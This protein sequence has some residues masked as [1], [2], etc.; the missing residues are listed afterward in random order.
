MAEFTDYDE[1]P[2]IEMNIIQK[3]QADIKRLTNY[4]AALSIK[5]E[6]CS[7]DYTFEEI[8]QIVALGEWAEMAAQEL[9]SL[10]TL[11][12]WR[13]NSKRLCEQIEGSDAIGYEWS[14][15]HKQQD[16]GRAAS[17]RIVMLFD[18]FKKLSVAP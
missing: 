11:V 14:Y 17:E 8:K 9:A 13:S 2:E 10:T 5:P 7:T 16:E 4:A 6:S 15:W 12:D 3:S 1:D 18:E